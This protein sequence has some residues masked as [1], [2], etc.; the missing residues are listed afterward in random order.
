M[1][2][3]ER[4]AMTENHTD[5]YDVLQISTKADPET[6]HRIYRILAQRF[7]P[8]NATTG[9]AE[10]FR[11]ITEAYQVLSDPER[12][13]QYDVHYG[14]HRRERSR[15]IAEMVR[16]QTDVEFEQLARMTILEALY[17]RR[18]LEP[19][20]PGVFD[21]DL[22]E[23]TG[24]AREQLEFTLWYLGQKGLIDRADG[25]RIAITAAGVEYFEQHC[26]QHQQML[27]L[28][29]PEDHSSHTVS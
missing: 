27:R 26:V 12:R 16:A 7:H 29:A 18:R 8:D 20:Q 28:T 23:L 21:G 14:E 25:S 15:L 17:A 5:F 4:M 6:I 1:V 24:R 11:T 22:E 10:R 2:R 13:A 19:R 3:P 9:D